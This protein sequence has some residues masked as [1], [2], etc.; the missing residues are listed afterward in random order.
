MGKDYNSF[1]L[2]LEKEYEEIEGEV[3]KKFKNRALDF[4]E[5]VTSEPPKGTPVITGYTTNSWNITINSPSSMR[6]GK[7][8]TAGGAAEAMR[9]QDDSIAK[10][11]EHKD[12]DTLHN[13]YINN[14]CDWISK[15]NSGT[16]KQTPAGFVELGIQY[17]ES[18][19]G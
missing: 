11:K 12:L 3:L 7:E 8:R 9:K 14:G 13:I 6:V 16:S 17:S 4:L 5:Y 1:N 10:L 2:E 15:L 18:R 19:G